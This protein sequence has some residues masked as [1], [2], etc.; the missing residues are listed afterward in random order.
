MMEEIILLHVRETEVFSIEI[1]PLVQY[2][3]TIQ[4]MHCRPFVRC[5]VMSH[6]I[7]EVSTNE[8]FPQ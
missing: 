3:N 4:H 6:H 8:L 7:T 1:A 2:T 5:T